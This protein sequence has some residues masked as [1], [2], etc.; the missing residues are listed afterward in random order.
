[1]PQGH[2]SIII[3]FNDFYYF[4]FPGLDYF[5]NFMNSG[6]ENYRIYIEFCKNSKNSVLFSHENIIYRSWRNTNKKNS[7]VGLKLYLIVFWQM[8]LF[9]WPL[10]LF[11][12][13]SIRLLD[14][15][16]GYVSFK[17]QTINAI[18]IE[19]LHLKDF[20]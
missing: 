2:L 18:F 15:T 17:I 12:Q 6:K 5:I 3:F 13:I 1:M 9:F 20:F 10:N 7:K 11:R 14:D 16:E 19:L 4:S 8:A